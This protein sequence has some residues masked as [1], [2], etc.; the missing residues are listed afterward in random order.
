MDIKNDWYHFTT[1]ARW[2]KSVSKAGIAVHVGTRR[3]ALERAYNRWNLEGKLYRL[4]I[5][6]DAAVNP[7]I[8]D[9]WDFGAWPDNIL[10][11][12]NY[13]VIPYYNAF[14]DVNSISLV[15]SPAVVQVIDYEKI[16]YAHR[17]DLARAAGMSILDST[18]AV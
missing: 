1:R 11:M 18:V 10:Q 13:D 17:N 15:C 2:Y 16:N 12:W 8:E 7:S 3:A 4:R 14:E 9:D 6:P 5:S